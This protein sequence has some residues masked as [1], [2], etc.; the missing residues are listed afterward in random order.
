M[1]FTVTT[2]GTTHHIGNKRTEKVLETIEGQGG[3]VRIFP[4]SSFVPPRETFARY[5]LWYLTLWSFRGAGQTITAAAVTSRMSCARN[6]IHRLCE[7]WVDR[8]WLVSVGRLNTG[9]AG[10]QPTGYRLTR[11]GKMQIHSWFT[12]FTNG[13]SVTV[14][15]TNA[16]QAQ[17]ILDALRPIQGV[18]TPPKTRT[19]VRYRTSTLVLMTLWIMEQ[20]GETASAPAIA[21]HLRCE[22]ATVEHTLSMMAGG[23]VTYA[24]TESRFPGK[25]GRPAGRYKLT[26]QGAERAY[27]HLATLLT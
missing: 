4:P 23:L 18:I 9:R 8:G 19:P 7:E 11:S 10:V 12:Y 25:G 13:L 15:T 3:T 1:Q 14:W 22:P 21:E 26:A 27:S 17:R 24:G 6:A 2:T 20:S 16:T 5:P